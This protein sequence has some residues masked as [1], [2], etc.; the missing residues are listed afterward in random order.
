[1]TALVGHSLDSSGAFNGEESKE[2]GEKGR[3][4]EGEEKKPVRRKRL[5][6]RRD[7]PKSE[8]GAP[9]Q[10]K[11]QAYREDFYA[12]SGKVSEIVRQLALAGIAIV[13]LLKVDLAAGTAL[14]TALLPPALLIVGRRKARSSRTAFGS[15]DRYLPCGLR[16]FSWSSSPTWRYSVSCWSA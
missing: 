15:N 12:F 8:D 4:K 9:G 6:D 16:K 14:P 10:M 2:G 3:T 5:E 11:L 1:V 7:R 13:W